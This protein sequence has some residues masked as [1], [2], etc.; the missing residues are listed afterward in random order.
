[1]LPR[2][3][4]KSMV[5]KDDFSWTERKDSLYNRLLMHSSYAFSVVASR[6]GT[7]VNGTN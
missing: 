5:T 3:E 1:M 6:L 4:P 2:I 7:C